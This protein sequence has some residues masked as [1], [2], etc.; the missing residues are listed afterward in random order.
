[1]IER[2]DTEPFGLRVAVDDQLQVAFRRDPLAHRVH[3]P[4]LPGR[5]D[6]EQGKRRRRGEEGLLRQVQHHRRILA[7]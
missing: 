5:V 4:K 7:D 6:M 1:M 3:V 2:V